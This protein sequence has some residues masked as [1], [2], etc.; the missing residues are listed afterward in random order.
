ML[1]ESLKN[2]ERPGLLAG[3]LLDQKERG[4]REAT[5]SHL[6]WVWKKVTSLKSTVVRKTYTAI[7]IEIVKVRT[8]RLG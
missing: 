8:V 4:W 2:L 6:S 3:L 7:V 1:P 5:K